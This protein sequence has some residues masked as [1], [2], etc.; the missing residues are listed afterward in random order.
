MRR[1]DFNEDWIFYT[2]GSDRKEKVT[3]PH[4]AMLHTGRSETSPGKDANGFYLGGIYIY[5]KEI[6]APVE[7][8]D[9]TVR[10]EFGGVYRN[11][12]VFVNGKKAG[13][14]PYG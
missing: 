2:E 12:T 9:Q 5:E 1:Q 14:R 4:D 3:L 8:K 7:W 11:T 10:I 13:F 6:F